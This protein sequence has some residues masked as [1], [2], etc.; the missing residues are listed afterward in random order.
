VITL[1]SR[2]L[3]LRTSFGGLVWNRPTA[4]RVDHSSGETRL[5]IRDVTR[6]GQL[7]LYG[8]SLLFVIAGLAAGRRR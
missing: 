3:K 6:R 2:S 4:V 5:P 7:I 1:E 8:L